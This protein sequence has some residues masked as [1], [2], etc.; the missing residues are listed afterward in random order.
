MEEASAELQAQDIENSSQQS[1][2][3]RFNQLSDNTQL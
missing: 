2:I 3:S 1:V